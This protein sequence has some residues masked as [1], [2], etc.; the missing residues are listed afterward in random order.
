MRNERRASGA[1]GRRYSRTYGGSGVVASNFGSEIGG[2]D[3]NRGDNSPA[4]QG[5]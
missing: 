5:T 2:W 3:T 4:P 1:Q